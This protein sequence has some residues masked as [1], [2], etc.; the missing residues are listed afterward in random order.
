[1]SAGRSDDKAL[2][3]VPIHLFV[4]DLSLIGTIDEGSG[5]LPALCHVVT[6]GATI[7]SM[8][9]T[10]NCSEILQSFSQL[11]T[12]RPPFQLLYKDI[13]A[14]LFTIPSTPCLLPYYVYV[15]QDLRTASPNT[16]LQ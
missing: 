8:E 14:T 5:L 13:R 15:P 11:S 12:S 4:E 2:L 1:M 6:E 3:Y 7:F 9:D 10:Y 16:Y